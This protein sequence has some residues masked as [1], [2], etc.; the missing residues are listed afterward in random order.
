MVSLNIE[1]AMAAGHP[2]AG[3]LVHGRSSARDEPIGTLRAFSY[4]K[5]YLGLTK[6]ADNRKGG[7]WK[8]D[9]AAGCELLWDGGDTRKSL[10]NLICE[11]RNTQS[12]HIVLPGGTWNDRIPSFGHVSWQPVL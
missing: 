4:C 6:R 12:V 10:P 5:C 1:S 11:A 9:R 8:T 3:V 7:V 2:A